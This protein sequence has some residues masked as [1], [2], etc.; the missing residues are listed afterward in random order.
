MIHT[1]HSLSAAG[2]QW[3]TINQG[4]SVDD[5]FT[6]LHVILM[7]LFDSCLYLLVTWYV[8]AIR[9]GE[10]GVPQPW[11]FP[12]MVSV[13]TVCFSPQSFSV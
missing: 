8:E 1:L 5:D 12:V 9:P 2:V 11:Y 3:S 13:Y 10:Y 4:S 7:L 6:M